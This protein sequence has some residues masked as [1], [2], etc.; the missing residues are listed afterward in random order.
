MADRTRVAIL[1]GGIAGLSAAFELTETDD[2][3]VTVYTTGW[4]LGGKG[5]SSN[6]KALGNRVEEHGLHLWFGFYEN[7]FDLMR[8]TYAAMDPPQSIDDHFTPVKEIVLGEDFHGRSVLRE[9]HPPPIPGQPG[10]GDHAVD[11][12][13]VAKTSLAW[14]LDLE[15]RA[16][17]PESIL[18]RLHSTA[19]ATAHFA[20]GLPGLVLGGGI[21]PGRVRGDVSRGLS[22]LASAVS[23]GA[24]TADVHASEA[25]L[26]QRVAQVLGHER[27]DMRSALELAYELSVRR[28]TNA[29]P[30]GPE[31]HTPVVNGLL[32]KYV[33]WLRDT[34]LDP[35]LED[36]DA[37]FLYYAADT[38]NAV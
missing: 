27:G 13:T 31:P 15:A 33:A 10:V 4:R 9:L 23:P 6:N 25:S 18:R 1:G 19:S 29:R 35:A 38:V 16:T 37:R 24:A 12:W 22:S 11:F 7:A 30:L 8:R 34:V 26:R 32:S 2:Y 3:D 28:A 5:A 21:G 20:L 36:D 14:L 17:T